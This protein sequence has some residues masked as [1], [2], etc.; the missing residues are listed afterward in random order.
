M[1]LDFLLFACQYGRKQIE[2]NTIFANVA[3]EHIKEI[4][5]LLLKKK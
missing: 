5:D 3:K 4:C 2:H 1:N